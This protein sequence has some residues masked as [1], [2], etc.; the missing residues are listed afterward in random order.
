MY[1]FRSRYV[2]LI[3]TLLGLLPAALLT[4][5]LGLEKEIKTDDGSTMVLVPAGEFVMGTATRQDYESP[6]HVVNLPAYYI[7]KTEVTNAQYARF[8]Q[9]TGHEPPP[10]WEGPNVPQGKENH[11]ITNV[12]WF[13]AM[14][15]AAWAG[16]RLPTE[17]EWEKAA[18]GT[19]GRRYP[20]G[21][22]DDL[23]KRNI[24]APRLWSHQHEIVEVALYPDGASPCGCLDMAGNAWE[25]TADWYM[26]YPH[27]ADRSIFYGKKYK[28]MRGGGGTG[29]LSRLPLCQ[30]RRSRQDPLRSQKTV[31]RC[32]KATQSLPA[33]TAN[34]AIRNLLRRAEKR[35]PRSHQSCG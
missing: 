31:G 6:P 12:S 4:P 14:Q 25:W 30:R 11:P 5:A 21:E 9:A 3:Y 1:T 27:T 7:D 35:P 20:W 10:T 15:Y 13:E 28:V 32:R 17:A 2:F 33:Q 8:L 23:D 26:P 16:K 34:I 22:L 19:D 24:P 29:W 18:R